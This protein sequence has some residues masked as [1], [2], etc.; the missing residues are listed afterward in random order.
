[1]KRYFLLSLLLFN[2][3]G[4]AT[5]GELTGDEIVM[6]A[7]Q[8]MIGNSAQYESLMV[9]KRPGVD[10]TIAKYITYFK[11]RGQKV[12][13]RILYPPEN[14]GKDLLLLNENMWQYVPNVEKSIRIAGT[15]RFMGGDFNNSDLLKVSLVDDY[16]AEVQGAEVVE[17]FQCYFMI[18]K[19][20]RPSATYDRVHY[21]VRKDGFIPLREEY[22]TLSGKKMKSLAYSDIGPLGNR[23]RPRLLTMINSLRPDHRT[24]VKLTN[25]EFDQKIP[26]YMFT[27]TYLERK[28]N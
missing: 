23:T 4:S 5:A 7:D 10:D 6:K 14:V 16:A 27:R 24:F 26:D 13:V 15:Q 22:Y 11:L 8:V 18:L 17:G 25:A 1:M 28:R 21:W 12:M 2:L 19:A 20:K 9:I 3:L